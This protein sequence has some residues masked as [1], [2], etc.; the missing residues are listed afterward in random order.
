MGGARETLRKIWT[1]ES[2]QGEEGRG[3]LTTGVAA[4]AIFTGLSPTITG[5][6][7]VAI[8]KDLSLPIRN[9]YAAYKN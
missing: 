8:F 1:V 3:L 7:A 6:E 2:G 9:A 5:V 4:V